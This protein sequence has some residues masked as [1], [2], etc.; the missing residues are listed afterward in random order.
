V[1]LA[2]VTHLISGS[3]PATEVLRLAAP[4]A[5]A[6]C[7]HFA[8]HRCT[9]ATRIVGQLP[10]VAGRAPP[11]ALRPTC[12][13]WNQEGVA[14]CLRCPQVV[15]EPLTPDALMRDLTVPQAAPSI[16]QPS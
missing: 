12:R 16:P 1:P 9:L 11:C 15:T 6:R 4:C 7:R 5:E 2:A 8:G 3:M 10:A 13:W 14:A